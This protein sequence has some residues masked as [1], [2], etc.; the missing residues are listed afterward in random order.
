MFKKFF[1]FTLFIVSFAAA[2]AQ[3]NIEIYADKTDL[4]LSEELQLTITVKAN[5]ADVEVS[6]LPSLPNFN[7]YSKRNSGR[8]TESFAR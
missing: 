2:F 6:D 4:D 8:Q 1:I 7:I 5:S 3:T